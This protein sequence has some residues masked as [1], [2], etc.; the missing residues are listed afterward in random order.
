MMRP[1]R[2]VRSLSTAAVLL[3]LGLLFAAGTAQ[4]AA[5]TNRKAE[6]PEPTRVEVEAQP[7]GFVMTQ[8]V[9]VSAAVQSDYDAAVRMVEQERY[10]SGIA[11]LQQVTEQAPQATA[12]HINLGIAYARRD[13]LD[14]AEESLRRA[15]ELNPRHPVAYNE[16]GLVQRRKG[17]FAAARRS[18]E[19]ALSVFPDFHYAHRNLGVLCD[20]Y[21]GEPGC[22]LEHYEA[23]ARA[24]PGDE[25]VTKW[26][27]ELRNRTAQGGNP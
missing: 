27:A 4:G 3:L 5:S 12:A 17:E 13:E 14:L 24:V 2:I 21:L 1:A 20:L 23:Y 18:Y 26:I 22:A 19:S 25:E 16:L 7:G 10:D 8:K 9:K 6:L 11:T 15:L